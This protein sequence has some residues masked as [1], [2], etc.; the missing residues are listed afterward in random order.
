MRKHFFFATC[1]IVALFIIT[2]CGKQEVKKNEAM[3]EEKAVVTIETPIQKEEIEEVEE[4]PEEVVEE[5]TEEV[6]VDILMPS[7][8]KYW[9][10]NRFYLY[11]FLNDCG[12]ESITEE[13]N[14]LGPEIS[15]IEAKFGS[16]YIDIY[17]DNYE[18]YANIYV[19]NEDPSISGFYK[20]IDYEDF[21]STIIISV[22]DKG[23]MVHQ[24]TIDSLEELIKAIRISNSKGEEKPIID[25]YIY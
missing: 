19:W 20:D 21:K 13:T 1:I 11:D 17:T 16:W 5:T 4:I 15:Y 2:G 24:I 9:N 25:G 14:N 8:E 6:E 10:L 23:T 7:A 3:I 12:A 22:D 18:Q